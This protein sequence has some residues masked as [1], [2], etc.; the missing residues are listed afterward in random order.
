MKLSL[1]R[2]ARR[3]SGD[4]A[5][6]DSRGSANGSIVGRQPNGALGSVVGGDRAGSFDSGIDG[7][8]AE[9]YL[10]ACAPP[11]PPRTP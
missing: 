11:P 5:N 8:A 7:W 9:N 3:S 2:R 10:V 4:G 1:G 6:L